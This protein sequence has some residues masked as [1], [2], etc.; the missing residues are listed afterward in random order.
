MKER[1][2][3][4]NG[5]SAQA[6][7]LLAKVYVRMGRAAGAQPNFDVPANGGGAVKA[8]AVVPIEEIMRRHP[9]AAEA[10]LHLGRALT[11]QGRM[12]VA[13]GHLELAVALNGASP[14][15]HFDAAKGAGQ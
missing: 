3:A 2:F 7:L 6:H 12:D 9:Q 5:A 11:E 14:Q 4:L 1:R 13:V 10:H 15:P 8:R